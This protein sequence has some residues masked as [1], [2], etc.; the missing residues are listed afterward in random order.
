MLGGVIPPCQL[1]TRTHT[2]E[3]YPPVLQHPERLQNRIGF[4]ARAAACR[5]RRGICGRCPSVSL[6]AFRDGWITIAL[7]CEVKMKTRLNPGSVLG[8][9]SSIATLVLI[10]A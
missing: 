2:L 8:I 1:D 3:R 5:Y 6:T 7:N 10:C 4:L 9:L